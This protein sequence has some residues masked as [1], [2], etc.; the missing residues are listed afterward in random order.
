MQIWQ[1]DNR[2]LYLPCKVQA[3]RTSVR[4]MMT[5]RP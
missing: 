4:V 1:K 5:T 3:G 2:T